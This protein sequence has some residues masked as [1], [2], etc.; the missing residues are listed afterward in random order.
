MQTQCEEHAHWVFRYAHVSQEL[1]FAVLTLGTF[2]GATVE[3]AL[4][5]GPF[6]SKIKFAVKLIALERLQHAFAQPQPEGSI[7]ILYSVMCLTLSTVM[8]CSP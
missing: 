4:D 8:H 1:F 3:A 2:F 6:S 7:T 5:R